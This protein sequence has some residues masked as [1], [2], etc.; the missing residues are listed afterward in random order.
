[1]GLIDAAKTALARNHLN[2][3]CKGIAKIETLVID[4]S[5]NTVKATISLAGEKEP[6]TI[7]AAYQL[8][9]GRNDG[10][11]KLDG[12]EA[13]RPWVAMACIR[14]VADRWIKIPTAARA[15]L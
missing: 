10:K 13:N 1:M 6:L 11:V 8:G 14:F 7:A 15:V 12:I 5:A 3:L 4:R 2:G 9:T